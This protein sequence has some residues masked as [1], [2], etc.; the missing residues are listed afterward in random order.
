MPKTGLEV[1]S[2]LRVEVPGSW[3][4]CGV[5]RDVTP[6]PTPLT[7]RMKGDVSP[8]IGLADRVISADE[9]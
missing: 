6:T 3:M 4:K 2:S 7:V 8:E 9:P 5:R 1:A